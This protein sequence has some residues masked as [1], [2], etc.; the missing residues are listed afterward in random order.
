M[1]MA[2]RRRIIRVRHVARQHNPVAAAARIRNRDRRQQR[3]R[4]WMERIAVQ[5]VAIGKLHHTAKVHH[6]HTVADVLD[7]AQIMRDEQIGETLFLLKL[8]HQVE[9]LRADRYVQRGHRFVADH[10]IRVQDQRTGNADSLPLSAGKLV[11]E[12]VQVL[13]AQTDL[14]QHLNHALAAFLLGALFKDLQ[15]RA[16]QILHRHA[17]VQGAVRIL[18]NN[19]QL[20]AHLP[21]LLFVVF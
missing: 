21:H 9:H 6:G 2:S 18:E 5:L 17:G 14:L 10:Q 8:A 16:N 3:L 19:L 20:A 7:H 15:R 1:E 11:R 12:A 4:I 13:F